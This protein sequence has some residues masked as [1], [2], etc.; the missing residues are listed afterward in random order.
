MM[1]ILFVLEHFYPYRGGVEFLFLHLGKSLVAKGY[2]VDVVTT[3]YD[4]SLPSTENM[5]GINIYRVDCNNRFL[6]SI[7]SIPL[8][9]KLASK[10][11][12]I[13]TST[14]A[15]AWPAWISS[16]LKRKKIIITFHEYWGNLWFELPYLKSWQRWIYRSY[17]K[18]ISLLSYDR[19]VAVSN[20]TKNE[21]LKSGIKEDKLAMVYNGVDYEDI[22]RLKN[23]ANNLPP[24]NMP[25]KYVLFVG[26]LG[27][28]KGFDLLLPSLDQYLS[29]YPESRA[30]V[31]IPDYPQNMNEIVRDLWA[32]L[33]NKNRI[34]LT[35]NLSRAELYNHMINASGILIPS[36]SEGFCFVAAESQALNVPVISSGKGALSEVVSS[37]YITVEEHTVEGYVQALAD[38]ENE[39]WVA[40][41][42]KRFT[43][44]AMVDDY[45][46][47]YNNLHNEQ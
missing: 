11:Q 33:T 27:V 44:D 15:A 38:H 18:M 45:C 10:A 2:E 14:Y 4:K 1:R 13:H 31:V 28:S 32:S 24:S 35:G 8:I 41:K 36:Y 22:A 19:I 25:N 9:M 16:V 6:F 43:L 30:V 7:L 20:F 40:G 37:K 23:I 39:K 17:E 47:I 5:D 34:L 12:V 29:S 21:L 46:K 26:R 42:T 3:W